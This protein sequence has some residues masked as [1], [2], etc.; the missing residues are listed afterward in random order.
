MRIIHINTQ[1]KWRGGERQLAWLY[2]EIEK[3]GIEQLLICKKKSELEVFSIQNNIHFKSFSIEIY[4]L[5]YVAFKLKKLIKKE[6]TIVHC[7]DSKS[8]TIAL[9]LKLFYRSKVKVVVQRKVNFTIKGLFS[10]KIK[11][12]EKYINAIFCVSK[13]VE[14]TIL[15]S[16][17]FRNTIV[18]YDMIKPF[19]IPTLNYSKSRFQ[20]GYI[21]ALTSE[22]DHFTFLN[23]A[24]NILKIYPNIQFVIAGEGKLKTEL[25]DYTAELGITNRVDFVGFIKDIPSLI[26]QI[27][28]LLFTSTSEGL[29]STILDFFIAKKPVVTVKNGGSEEL[30][31]HNQ[32]GFICEPKDDMNLSKY[33]VE[34]IENP[35]LRDNITENA[36][37]FVIENFSV[38]IITEKI[39]D[40]YTK[41]L[42]NESV[43]TINLNSINNL[44]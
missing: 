27:D 35:K 41:I 11:Y 9:I 2:E 29:G 4:T 19:E 44:Q 33:C 10:K 24:K 39:L 7:H 6:D 30:V 18:I 38:N 13:S 23:T 31:F 17:G 36:Y 14:S 40:A 34:L 12:S 28:I 22:K 3:N 25:M 15:K 8:H 32:T 16:T 21:A 1:K 42:K 26:A 20:I 43:V 37:E 5:F